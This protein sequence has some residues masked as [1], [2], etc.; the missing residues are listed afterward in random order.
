MARGVANAAFGVRELVDRVARQAPAR[1]AVSVFGTVIALVTVLLWLPWATASGHQAPFVDA[2]FTATS[3]T[4][5]TGL[6]VVP[7]GTYWSTYGLVVILVA[8]K[9]GGL[10]VMTL[11][12]KWAYAMSDAQLSECVRTRPRSAD[13]RDALVAAGDRMLRAIIF[14]SA[15]DHLS[16]QFDKV[17]G[18]EKSVRNLTWSYAAMLSA[19]RGRQRA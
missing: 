9:V 4:T 17:T 12:P 3:A 1:L 10:G 8:I 5:V 2:L 11:A 18:Y 13:D 7:T 19:L 14:H 6:V 16:E 15:S